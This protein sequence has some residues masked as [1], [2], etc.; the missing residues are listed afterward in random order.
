MK[1][2]SVLWLLIAP[3]AL[4][5]QGQSLLDKVVQNEIE[6]AWMHAQGMYGFEIVKVGD[7]IYC[8][9]LLE[10]ATIRLIVSS[11]TGSSVEELRVWRSAEQSSSIPFIYLS[12]HH[13]LSDA[14]WGASNKGNT[15]EEIIIIDLDKAEVV[16]SFAPNWHI[17]GSGSGLANEGVWDCHY[18]T[19]YSLCGDSIMIE[20]IEILAAELKAKDSANRKQEGG[21]RRK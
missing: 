19:A 17:S 15:M 11:I 7:D 13:K 12:I 16:F 8:V 3:L 14:S 10:G 5:A 2:I 9:L 18:R 20:K 1:V 6:T 4:W 21:G